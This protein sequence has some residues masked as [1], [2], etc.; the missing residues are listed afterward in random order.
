M[1]GAVPRNTE[2]PTIDGKSFERCR[3]YLDV[4]QHFPLDAVRCKIKDLEE[5]LTLLHK[6]VDT[7]SMANN[8]LA[9]LRQEAAKKIDEEDWS[10]T[11]D[12][13]TAAAILS[14][15]RP[16]LDVF[17][18]RAVHRIRSLTL[19]LQSARELAATME[20]ALPETKLSP[21][22]SSAAQRSSSDFLRNAPP[23][24]R[25]SNGLRESPT[26]RVSDQSP[27]RRK[28]NEKKEQ[29]TKLFKSQSAKSLWKSPFRF[30]GTL[31]KKK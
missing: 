15:N 28:A 2:T 10:D 19:T 29:N 27:V 18:D 5:Q 3:A 7:M 6:H 9:M 17:I 21:R 31:A 22:I 13:Q 30:S 1:S 16:R 4:A 24:Q 23:T 20:Q 26:R 12:E 25:A 14:I 11:E 8:A